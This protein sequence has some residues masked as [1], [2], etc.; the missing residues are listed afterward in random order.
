MW[1]KKTK[2]D[3]NAHNSFFSLI[4]TSH[5]LA[6]AMEVL[7]MDS[8]DDN[9]SEF[10]VPK[11][12]PTLPKSERSKIVNHICD[13]IVHSYIDLHHSVEVQDP[14]RI[15]SKHADPSKNCCS[16]GEEGTTEEDFSEGEEDTTEDE[17]F[18]ECEESSSTDEHNSCKDEDHNEREKK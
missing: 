13:V 15:N 11:D 6:A 7:S 2:K 9:P 17:G 5:I 1:G 10:L 3:F 16:K 14:E 18:S 8:L 12:I 4:T